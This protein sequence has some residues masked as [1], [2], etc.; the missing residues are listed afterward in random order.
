MVDIK[1]LNR[2]AD[3]IRIL[4]AAMVE[5]PNQGIQVVLWEAQTLLMS[6]ILSS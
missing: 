3:N 1:T 5:K 6:F 2:A 4:T